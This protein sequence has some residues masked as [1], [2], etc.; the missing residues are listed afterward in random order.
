M[1]D[2]DGRKLERCFFCLQASDVRLLTSGLC[3]CMKSLR[4]LQMMVGMGNAL[5]KRII[6]FVLLCLALTPGCFFEDSQKKAKRLYECGLNALDEKKTDTAMSC[7]QQAV[8]ED[9]GHA[10]AHCQLGRLYLK[11]NQMNLAEREFSLALRQDPG[12]TDA[13]RSLARLFY[14][15]GAYEEAIP[16]FRKLIERHGED[17]G[18]R[19]ILSDSLLGIGDVS[20]AREVMEKTAADYPND[21]P[22]QIALARFYEKARLFALPEKTLRKIRDDFP[23]SSRPYVALM[24]FHMRQG[25][26][27]RAEETGAEAIKKGLTDK[28]LHHSLFVLENRRKNHK[29]ALRHLESAVEM[30][31]EDQDLWMLLGDYLLFLKM[32]PQAREAYERIGRKWPDSRHI[33]TRIAEVYMAE[34]RYDE[35]LKYVEKIL[36]KRTGDARAHLLRGLLWIREG[37]TEKARAE[38]LRARELDPESAEGH[39]FYGLSFLKDQEYE[40]SL[41]EILRAVEKDPDSSK[42]R[43]ALAYVYFKMGQFFL[44]LDELDQILAAQPDNPRARALRATVRIRLKDYEAAASDY[45]YMIQKGLSTPE[46]RF[47][48]AETYKALGR[49][50]DALKTVEEALTQDPDSL[51][52]LEEKAR[53]YVAQGAYEKAIDVCNS[54]LKNH[55]DDLQFGM[56]KSSILLK[57][58]KYGMAEDLLTRLIKKYPQSYRPVML[59]AKALRK[60]RKYKQALVY[61]QKAVDRDPKA[62][63]AYMEMAEAC[64]HAGQFDRAMDAYEVVLRLDGS[65]GPAVNDL[66]YLYADRNQNLDRALSLALKAFELMPESP[67]VRDTLGW[68]Y[69]K[70]GSVLLAKMHLGQAVRRSPETPLFHY[71]LGVALHASNDLT[72][73]GKAFREAIRLGLE[74]KELAS[75]RNMLQQIKAKG[76]S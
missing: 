37:N 15:R 21:I 59:M 44:A 13:E 53:I 26:L 57:Q 45:R 16:L 75:A 5:R 71:H 63:E 10:K 43:L 70:K 74:G 42:A 76:V 60:Q 50:D 52:G 3:C 4:L 12:L 56:L 62:I 40:L 20:A 30:S 35:A 22:I 48:L 68:A 54:Y 47:H 28:D 65:Y 39:Y 64:N 17:P 33:Q 25:R 6:V 31:P 8:E 66:A 46:I 2:L 18:T 23:K 73:A 51:K 9:P 49:L 55:P 32:Y 69:L 72:G 27:D 41:P 61:Y 67:A 14:Q 36:A 1:D 29:A 7:F 38:I 24:E 11:S 58:D 34:G 19:V